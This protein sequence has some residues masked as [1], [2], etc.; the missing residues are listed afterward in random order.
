MEVWVVAVELCGAPLEAVVEF[1][2]GAVEFTV[3]VGDVAV[4]VET[5]EEEAEITDTV[6]SASFAVKISP[7]PES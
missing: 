3:E 4:E 5:D 1:D 6:A 2:A 7:F